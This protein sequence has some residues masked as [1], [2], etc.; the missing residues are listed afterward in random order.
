MKLTRSRN[1]MIGGV[2]AGL[3]KSLNLDVTIVRIA[4]ILISI[5]MGS[6]LLIYC[7]L[8]AVIPR[9]EGGSL[10]EDGFEKA[11][12]WYDEQQRKKGPQGPNYDI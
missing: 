10:A 9:E 4:F 3:A 5:F 12:T 7:I 1:G 6:G 2:A 8:W 11:K